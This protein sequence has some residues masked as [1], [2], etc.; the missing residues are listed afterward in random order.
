MLQNYL[1]PFN[2]NTII[3]FSLP[4]QS[5]VTLKVFD[6][7]GRKV[8]TLINAELTAGI[9]NV[10]FNAINLNSGVYFYRIEANGIDGSKFTSV[11]KMILLK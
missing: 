11:K 1:N 8:A 6:V 2:P 9:H 3:K 10:N 5:K 4:A 7:L